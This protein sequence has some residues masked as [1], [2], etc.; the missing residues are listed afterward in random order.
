[1]ID[2]FIQVFQ[3]FLQVITP[4]LSYFGSV[5]FQQTPGVIVQWREEC[6]LQV[7]TVDT[8]EFSINLWVIMRDPE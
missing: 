8:E 6:G 3:K 4:S 2:L 7:N 1:M 5:H